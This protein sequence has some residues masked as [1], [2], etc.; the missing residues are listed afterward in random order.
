MLYPGNIK[1]EYTHF[2]SYANRGM[3]LEDL[4]NQSNEYYLETNKAV[5]YKKPTPITISEVRYSNQERVIT[6]AYFR[7][8]STLDYNGIYRGR[9]ID[10]D[11]K[12]CKNKTAFPLSNVH[13][14][15]FEHI[16]RVIEHGGIAFLIIAMNGKTF[17]LDGKIILDF[18]NQNK[19]KSI[20][21][22]FIEEY[23]VMIP[24]KIRP[25]LD[26]LKAIDEIY[27]KE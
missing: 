22:S 13:E 19:R 16:K 21:F 26:Y 9:Y 7:T 18:K 27:F 5:I 6:K 3:N 11:A 14:H 4:I 10:F 15:Q 2:T 24:E 23:G 17:C 12:E 1:K 20:P 8:P 25:R